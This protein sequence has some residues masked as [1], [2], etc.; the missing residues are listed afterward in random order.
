MRAI[1]VEYL[2]PGLVLGRP[3]YDNRGNVLLNRGITLTGSYI[4]S[5]KAKGFEFVYIRDENDL[6]IE[7]EEDLSP[8]TRARAK[9]TLLEAYG[10]IEKEVKTLRNESMSAMIDA[11]SS[12]A[13][14]TLTGDKGPLSRIADVVRAIMEEVLDRNSLAGLATIRT[15]DAELH[16]HSISVCVVALMIGRAVGVPDR[17]MRQLAA[18]CLLHDLGRVFVDAAAEPAK[19]IRQ[20]TLL[21]FELL[22][23][24]ENGSILAPHVAL[25][26][27]EHQDGT[28]LPRGTRSSNTLER[29]RNL[30][31]PIPTLIGEIAAVANYYDN[32][33]NGRHGMKP[34]PPDAAL[35]AVCEAAGTRFNR[36]VVDAFL[37]CVPVYPVGAEIVVRSGKYRGYTGVVSEVSTAALDR[38]TI[39]LNR[40]AQRKPAVPITLDLRQEADIEIQCRGIATS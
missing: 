35:R 30:P 23:N 26:H 31:P 38:P 5:L 17:T 13:I 7:P 10:A 12:D 25:E 3:L 6:D 32:V 40:D 22:R 8:A 27:H 4:A 24:G 34:A 28:G 16:D 2:K 11:C 18:G 29:D 19:Q 15:A 37:R 20:H 9:S 21:G 14:K 36:T 33:L 1:F 39:V